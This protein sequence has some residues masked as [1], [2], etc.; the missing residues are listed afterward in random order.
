MKKLLSGNAGCT[1]AA[2]VVA[3]SMH[4]PVSIKPGWCI[5]L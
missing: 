3:D 5:Y 4:E 1:L 2:L